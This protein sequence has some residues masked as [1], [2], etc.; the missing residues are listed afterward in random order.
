MLPDFRGFGGYSLR[1]AA[2][3]VL[4]VLIGITGTIIGLSIFLG[5]LTRYF[6]YDIFVQVVFFEWHASSAWV[7]WL[8]TVSWGA[9]AIS[10]PARPRQAK[11]TALLVWMVLICFH[12]VFHTLWI[13][14]FCRR[15]HNFFRGTLAGNVFK[16]G[17]DLF[18]SKYT[19]NQYVQGFMYIA[20]PILNLVSAPY[21]MRFFNQLPPLNVIF[22]IGWNW[23]YPAFI[24]GALPVVFMGMSIV[25]VLGYI[26]AIDRGGNGTELCPPSKIALYYSLHPEDRADIRNGVQRIENFESLDSEDEYLS[27]REQTKMGK[28][29][30]VKVPARDNDPGSSDYS[31]NGDVKRIPSYKPRNRV[32]GITADDTKRSYKRATGTSLV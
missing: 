27:S 20:V 31:E 8:L 32:N 28:Q 17:V 9:F 22:W 13:V 29:Q 21:T 23:V 15:C 5:S 1:A 4:A 24:L 11:R 10:L 3:L 18:L 12:M 2:I 19:H 25:I 30:Q 16:G 6:A 26:H 14:L 7:M